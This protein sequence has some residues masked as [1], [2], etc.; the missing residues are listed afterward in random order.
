M[1]SAQYLTFHFLHLHL[2]NPQL[3]LYNPQVHFKEPKVPPHTLPLLQLPDEDLALIQE[4]VLQS[5]SLK[6]LAEARGVSYPT[7]RQ[8]LD[9]VIERLQAAIAG[10]P[11][12]PLR[13]YLATLIERGHLTPELAHRVLTLAH[14]NGAQQ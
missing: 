14:Q 3:T 6:G 12:D 9:R 10:R 4:L 13:D 5:G 1:P 7:I 2:D 8:R 11:P